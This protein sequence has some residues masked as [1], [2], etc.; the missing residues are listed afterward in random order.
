MQAFDGFLYKTKNLPDLNEEALQK[1]IQNQS[2]VP[3]SLYTMT[4]SS[5]NR[6][7]NN[8][9]EGVKHGSYQRYLDDKKGKQISQVVNVV[10]DSAKQGNKRK[11]YTIT[12]YNFDCDCGLN[13]EVIEDATDLLEEGDE[14]GDEETVDDGITFAN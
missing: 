12:S 7:I 5:L 14:E 6:T 1:R 11:A 8:K 13:D 10:A 3:S 9:N 2:R 4:F